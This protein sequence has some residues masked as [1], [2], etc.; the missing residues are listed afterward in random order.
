MPLSEEGRQVI[1]LAQEWRAAASD[2]LWLPGGSVARFLKLWVAT[3]ALFEMQFS[4]VSGDR[5]QVLA[6]AAWQPVVEAHNANRGRDTYRQAIVALTTPGVW[7]YRR[8]AYQ[9]IGPTSESVETMETV[10]QVRCNLF[11]GRKS[12]TN[13]RDA[14]LI[15]AASRITS[16]ILDALFAAPEDIWTSRPA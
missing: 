5:N 8:N 12:P 13:S 9:T 15:G 10:Y 1:A 3:N 16:V 2:D 7:N 4:D 11:H 6:F 14:Q